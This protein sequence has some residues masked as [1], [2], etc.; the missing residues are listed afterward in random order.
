M[1]HRAW[2]LK[3]FQH[4]IEVNGF[5]HVAV[6]DFRRHRAAVKLSLCTQDRPFAD[7]VVLNIGVM[8]VSWQKA[9]NGDEKL[10]LI[11]D[12]V[13]QEAAC[14]VLAAY[15]QDSTILN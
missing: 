15:E 1:S 4:E 9:W 8:Y 6:H 14:E 5:H 11:E 12:E 2:L 7:A 3:Y 10:W 13:L